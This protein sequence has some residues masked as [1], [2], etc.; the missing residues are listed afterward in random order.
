MTIYY[1]RVTAVKNDYGKT[2]TMQ[3]IDTEEN[4]VDLSAS[5]KVLFSMRKVGE[6]SNKVSGQ[7][8]SVSS[9]SSGLVTYTFASGDITS[10]GTYQVQVSY[11]TSGA[12]IT[13]YGFEI[14]IVED[15][16]PR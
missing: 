8:C 1:D 16:L 4:P 14:A 10:A 15:F 9:A 5:G 13:G 2:L 7:T 12:E 11:Q 6:T 3:L